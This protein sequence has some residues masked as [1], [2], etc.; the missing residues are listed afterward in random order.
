MTSKTS[1]FNL[2]IYKST[3]KRYLWGGVLYS[4]LIFMVT[5]MA[6]FLNIGII[7]PDSN[8]LYWEENPLILNGSYIA[9][10]LILAMFVPTVAALLIF[11]FVHSKNQAVFTHCLPI[12]RRA[13]FIS[14]ISAAFT[15]MFVPIIL[16]ACILFLIS[17]GKYGEYFTALDC[18][19]WAAINMYAIFLMFSC[20]ALAVF[21]TGN[22]IGMIA[23]NILIH[24]FLVLVVLTLS[25]MAELFIYGY[26]S[27]NAVIEAV[28]THNFF[29]V[30]SGMCT[31]YFLENLS[32]LKILGYALCAVILY[33]FSYI[34]YKKRKLENVG[35]VA[36]FKCLNHIFKYMVCFLVTMCA[37]ATFGSYI[38]KNP[39]A[40]F[41]IILIASLVAYAASEMVLKKTLKVMYSWKG[42]IAFA[43]CFGI[44][45]GVFYGTS[46]F[47]YEKRLPE[48]DS[49]SKVLITNNSY[50]SNYKYTDNSMIIKTV[51]DAHHDLI[52]DE[53]IP[54][55]SE[56]YTYEEEYVYIFIKYI[57]KDGSDFERKYL[58]KGTKYREIMDKCYEIDEY[59]M[60]MEDVF[61]DDSLITRISL[62][63]Y[64]MSELSKEEI[65]PII[66]ED[67]M[68][69]SYS[70]IYPYYEYY[71]PANY[72]IHIEYI[73]RDNERIN[74]GESYISGIGISVT[75]K[76]VRTEKY[77]KEKG[78]A[79]VN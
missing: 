52:K 60:L 41:T 35:D 29:T 19:K 33:A 69:L 61:T 57:L 64:E 66:R 16:N 63:N 9:V 75:D 62:N 79:P 26:S 8:S 1:F 51:C 28:C 70:D 31:S 15:L 30:V 68:D 37:F 50:K 36:G 58:I 55:L 4:V 24:S 17:F 72:Y 10:P 56:P 7:R 20:A 74:G 27:N 14:Q 53:S 12:S 65:L 23:V 76:Y 32:L 25:V 73:E 59:K 11:R 18:L 77:L 40:F 46:F 3:V 42:Y 13:N 21:L 2:G 38:G 6:I 39:A 43:I 44:M 22:S 71:N 47:G 54:K 34:L 45:F 49:I 67:I 78:Y 48:E 5:G